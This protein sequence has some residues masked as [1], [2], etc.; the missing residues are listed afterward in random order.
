MLGITSA[1]P[2]TG[3]AP[4]EGS[5][6]R[7]RRDGEPR[8]GTPTPTP[9]PVRLLGAAGAPPAREWASDPRAR[10][11]LDPPLHRSR[12]QPCVLSP[13]PVNLLGRRSRR[14]VF[15]AKGAPPGLR[16]VG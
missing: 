7:V 5:G 4:A 2:E 15:V 8:P 6:G 9:V 14:S 3:D 11:A 10:A 16:E 12:D 13:L 1:A